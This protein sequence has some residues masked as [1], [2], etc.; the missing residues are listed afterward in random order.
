M[1]SKARK[2]RNPRC[3]RNIGPSLDGGKRGWHIE[4]PGKAG[5]RGKMPFQIKNELAYRH[6][7]RQL[8]ELQVALRLANSIL[9]ESEYPGLRKGVEG[10]IEAKQALFKSIISMEAE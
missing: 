2:P 1:S 4:L 9:K 3:K 7:Q 5:E 8:G 6:A 10:L